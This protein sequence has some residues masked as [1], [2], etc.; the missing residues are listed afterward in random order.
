MIR[1]HV[2]RLLTEQCK[3]MMEVLSGLSRILSQRDLNHATSGW[4][5]IGSEDHYLNE[6]FAFS[7]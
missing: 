7:G 6:H 4:P 5:V 1:S 3:R 2:F